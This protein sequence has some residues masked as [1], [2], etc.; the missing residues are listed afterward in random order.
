MQN[1]GNTVEQSVKEKTLSKQE[2]EVKKELEHLIRMLDVE[3]FRVEM[4]DIEFGRKTFEI[5]CN[6]QEDRGKVIGRNGR[7]INA[8]QT[9][10]KAYA[11]PRGVIFSGI[12]LND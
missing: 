12:H 7:N 5:Y 11:Q 1:P 10:V 4:V 6:R 9:L 8:L 2:L 3:E